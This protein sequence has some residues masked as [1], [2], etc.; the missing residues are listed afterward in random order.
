MVSVNAAIFK[1]LKKKEERKAR[2]KDNAEFIAKVAG[3]P[4]KLSKEKQIKR[5]KEA[6][7]QSCRQVVLA[8]DDNKCVMGCPPRPLNC[9]HWLFRRSHSVALAFEPDNVITLC[10]YPCH[11]GYIHHDGDGDFIMRMC[12]KMISRI[13]PE[14]VKE[15]QEI[16]AHPYP[17]DLAW[18]EQKNIEL[19]SRLKIL[20]DAK[21]AGLL[22]Y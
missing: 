5:I 19:K 6:N 22:I 13:G 14:R 12:E 20:L 21:A 7:W 4:K 3:K 15:M 1:A 16:A 10:A 2:R 17:L 8:R 9:H 18:H 11:L